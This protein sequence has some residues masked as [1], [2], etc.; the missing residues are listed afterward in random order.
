M[1]Q[2]G[3]STKGL[4]FGLNVKPDF[5]CFGE[6]AGLVKVLGLDLDLLCA[7]KGLEN[8]ITDLI[9]NIIFK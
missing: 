3:T 6:T 4:V 7:P 2:V 5:Y 8:C 9:L 1:I